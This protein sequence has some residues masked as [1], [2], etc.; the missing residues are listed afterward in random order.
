MGSP[1]HH[2]HDGLDP[3]AL[4]LELRM[5]NGVEIAEEVAQSTQEQINCVTW[6]HADNL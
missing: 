5:V 1:S 4:L 2:F 3:S 6:Y